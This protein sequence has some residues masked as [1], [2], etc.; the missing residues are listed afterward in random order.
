MLWYDWGRD[1]KSYQTLSSRLAACPL[2]PLP[3]FPKGKENCID[4]LPK[5]AREREQIPVRRNHFW[6]ATCTGC[7]LG[8][9]SGGQSLLSTV[10]PCVRRRPGNLGFVLLCHKRG[11]HRLAA[12]L[13]LRCQSL[14]M[15][16]V[17]SHCHCSQDG[18]PC[19]WMASCLS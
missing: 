11:W 19:V 9:I 15:P 17:E 18:G 8:A 2:H 3:H 1:V 13:A 4:L 6:Q 7:Q 16:G 14:E 10:W 12:E 5:G